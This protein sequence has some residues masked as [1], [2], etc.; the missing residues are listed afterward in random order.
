MEPLVYI[1]LGVLLASA[2][3]IPIIKKILRENNEHLEA[4]HRSI[5]KLLDAFIEVTQP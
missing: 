2:L 3:Y 1:M 5:D 4:E